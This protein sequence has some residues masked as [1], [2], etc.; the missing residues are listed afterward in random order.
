[1]RTYFDGSVG[2][3]EQGDTFIT[4]AGI[5]GTDEVW[6][7]FDGKCSRMLASRYPVAPYIHMIELLDNKDPSEEKAGWCFEKKRQL[8]QDAIV[9]LSQMDKVGFMTVWSSIRDSLRIRLKNEGRD[10][11]D[12]PYLHC[13]AHCMYFT[14]AKYLLSVSQPLKEPLYDQDFGSRSGCGG[15]SG[16]FRQV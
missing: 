13:A 10:V 15:F 2:Q 16:Q 6:A 3:D 7:E 1:M 12:D 8:I 11:P 14:V 4:F 9:L 5:A